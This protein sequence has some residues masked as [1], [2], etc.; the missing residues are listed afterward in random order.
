M[1]PIGP[2]DDI[3]VI[4]VANWVAAPSCTALLADMGADVIKVEPLSGDGMRGRLRQPIM[5]DGRPPIDAGFQ[6]DNRGKRSVAI[7]L[8]DERGAA[9][10]ASLA[11]GAD[12]FVTNLLPRRLNRYRLGPDELRATRPS[13]I[14]A[15][16]TGYGSVGDEA[17][18]VAFDLAAFFGRG[19][20]MSLIGEPDEPPPGFRAGQ[21]DHPTG[22]ALL[23]AVLAALRVR[24]RTGEGQVVETAL[25]RTAAWTIGCDVSVALIDR[26]QPARRSRRDAISPMH[27]RYKCADDRWIN[28]VA[29]DTQLWPAFCVAAGLPELA[30]DP[31]YAT[32]RDRFDRGPELIAIFEARFASKPAA[33]WVGPLNNSGIVWSMVAELPE[34][35]EDPQARAMDMYVELADPELG[36]FETLAAP[37]SLSESDL[38]A[39]GPAPR[40]GEHTFDVLSELGISAAEIKEMAADQVITYP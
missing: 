3:R 10:V 18:R 13:L 5:P 28:I 16:V 19:G 11:D 21:G 30:D 32:P 2:M 22:L 36:S 29:Q 40:V 14:Y 17:D 23:S 37:F 6:L 26:H 7:D 27:T 33:D 20:I 35:V 9:L 25:L 39:R 31:R 1:S 34:V 8:N 12:V 15:L 38:S 24:D 4:E